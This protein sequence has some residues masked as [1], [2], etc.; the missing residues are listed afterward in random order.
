[1]ALLDTCNR[2]RDLHAG[3]V[4][5]GMWLFAQRENVFMSFVVFVGVLLL[6]TGH[7]RKLEGPWNE[8]AEK[9]GVRPAMV[10]PLLVKK[11]TYGKQDGI[12]VLRISSRKRWISLGLEDTGRTGTQGLKYMP[13]SGCPEPTQRVIPVRVSDARCC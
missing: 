11:R 4:R 5:Y 9:L 13:A 3:V 8:L 2:L 7:C 1:M 12:L 6:C 10:D